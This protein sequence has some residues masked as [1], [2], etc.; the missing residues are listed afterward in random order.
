MASFVRNAQ[1]KMLL[2]V[3][4]LFD[5]NQVIYKRLHKEA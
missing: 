4:S 3:V 1:G 2:E 5:Y